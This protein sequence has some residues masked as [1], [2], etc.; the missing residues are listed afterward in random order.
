MKILLNLLPEE[1]KK[2]MRRNTR[3]RMIVAHGSGIIFLGFFYCCVLLGI[4]VLLSL[5]LESVRGSMSSAEASRKSER[6]SYEVIFRKTNTQASEVMLLLGKHVTWERFFRELESATPPGV[7]YTKLL[8]KNDFS[9]SLSGK[10]PDRES[11]LSLERNM[12]DSACFRAKDESPMVPLSNK[13]VKENIEFQL[14][15]MIEKTCL[16]SGGKEK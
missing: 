14:D 11:L 8:A 12:N 3:F 9:L 16:V 6:D 15:A 4:S 13:L 10:A 2:E 7:S 1:K 5:Q